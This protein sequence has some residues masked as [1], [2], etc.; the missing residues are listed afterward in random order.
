M[1]NAM[2]SKQFDLNLGKMMHTIIN[3]R[4]MIF[5]FMIIGALLAFE[6]FNYSTTEFALS[7][8]LGPLT[9]VG[10]HWATILAIAFCS[11]DFA[12]VARLFTPEQGDN[13]PGE[14]WYLFSAWVLAAIMN[15]SLTWWGVSVAIASHTSQGAEVISNST[16][17]TVVPIFVAVLVLVIRIMIIGTF[18]VSGERMFGQTDNRSRRNTPQ[19]QPQPYPSR[20]DYH[21][22]R[23]TSPAAQALAARPM[24]APATGFKP[25]PKPVERSESSFS[26]SSDPT[27]HNLGASTRLVGHL[28]ERK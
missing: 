22:Q 19:S 5:G 27:Y 4:S 9:F 20:S 18:S 1:N 12:G 3:R 24:L 8:M 23:P 13:E 2:S 11:I 16:I 21:P 7:D 26:G 25:Q 10:V 15:A 28:Q 17:Q 14:A 6:I